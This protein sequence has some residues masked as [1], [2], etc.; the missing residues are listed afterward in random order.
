MEIVK[1]LTF[2]FVLSLFSACASTSNKTQPSHIPVPQKVGREIICQY[3]NSAAASSENRAGSLAVY[4]AGKPNAPKSGDCANWSGYGFSWTPINWDVR[5]NLLLAYEKPIHATSITVI[6]DYDMC[7]SSIK[8]VNSVTGEEKKILNS[9]SKECV[10][11]IQL[12]GTFK[13]DRVMLESCG[14]A[15]SATDAV[16]ICGFTN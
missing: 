2:L 1:M 4:A 12:D 5:A 15:W 16:E 9:I 10:L 11:K 7:W 6:G 13:A 3:A 14:S 8:L